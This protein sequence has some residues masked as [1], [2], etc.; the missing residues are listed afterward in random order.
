MQI[1]QVWTCIRE[2]GE[3]RVQERAPWQGKS[4]RLAATADGRRW[5]LKVFRVC[6]FPQL[7]AFLFPLPD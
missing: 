7:T 4:N 2:R 1:S 5:G 3:V 6:S